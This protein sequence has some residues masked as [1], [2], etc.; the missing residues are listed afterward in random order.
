MIEQF[1]IIENLC[2]VVGS[3]SI[4]PIPIF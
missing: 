3:M 1:K 4:P 2:I